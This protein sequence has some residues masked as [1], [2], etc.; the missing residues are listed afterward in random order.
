MKYWKE[1]MKL[2]YIAAKKN[3][4]PVG[5]I[6]VHNNKIIAKGYNQ[7]EKAHNI[8]GHAEIIAIKKAS[9]RLKTWKLSDCDLYVSLKPC[10]MCEEII[11]QSRLQNVYFLAEKPNFKKE[12]SETTFNLTPDLPYQKEYLDLLSDFFKKLR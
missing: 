7:R 4:V 2:C 12:Y 10:K 6:I 9:K 11:K 8:L 5:A 3:E 1:I